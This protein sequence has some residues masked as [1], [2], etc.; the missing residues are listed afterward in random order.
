MKINPPHNRFIIFSGG[1]GLV[2]REQT[3]KLSA[4]RNIIEILDVPSSFDEDTVSVELEGS[5]AEL[6]QIVVKKPDRRFV[7][8]AMQRERQAS[9]RILSESVDIRT[10]LREELLTICEGIRSYRYEDSFSELIIT[11]DAKKEEMGKIMI[12]YF[13]D[14]GRIWWTPSIQVD[15]GENDK[16]AR[17]TGY[18]LVENQ[19]TLNFEDVELGFV[20]FEGAGRQPPPA[21]PSRGPPPPPGASTPATP[22]ASGRPMAQLRKEM[23][24]ELRKVKSII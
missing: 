10:E 1:G 13:L 20:E 7:E 8:D 21:P 15:I 4:G 2:L 22:P 9:E 5:E 14:D 6:I 3:I 24:S 17:I 23:M 12:S 19:T 16:E 18:I 11:I